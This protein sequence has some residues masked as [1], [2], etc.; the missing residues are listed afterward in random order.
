MEEDF[1]AQLRALGINNGDVLLVHSSM[2]AL[3]T[4]KSPQ[5]FIHDLINVLGTEGTLLMPA[6]TYENVNANQPH[7]S[8]LTTEPCIG[9][10]PKTFLLMDGVIRSIHPTHSICAYGKYAA[11]ITSEHLMDETPVGPHSPFIKLMS[12]N[13]KILFIGN[14]LASCTFMHGLEEIV[15]SPY[16]LEKKRTHY[17]IENKDGSI[18]EKDM[19]AHNFKG[20]EQQYQRIKDILRYPE[21]KTGKVGKADCYLIDAMALAE[22]AIKK[23]NEDPYF[24]VTSKTLA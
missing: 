2:K 10:I 19:F 6:L 7:F 4:K 18:I 16:V 21:I 14:I 24:F 23:F 9:L 5:E 13:G 22:K 20:W 12:Y 17:I 1:I 3:K 8:V 15:G 11:D